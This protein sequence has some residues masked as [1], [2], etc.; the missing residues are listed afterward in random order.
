VRPYTYLTNRLWLQRPFVVAGSA[1]QHR[2][3]TAALSIATRVSP[4]RAQ[5]VTLA[6]PAAEST[7]PARS[8]ESFN[9]AVHPFLGVVAFRERREFRPDI[10]RTLQQVVHRRSHQ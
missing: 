3:L 8:D 6:T 5:D 1:R 4:V 2:S 10:R 7:A 9:K